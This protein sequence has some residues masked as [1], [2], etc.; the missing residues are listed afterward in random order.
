MLV[1]A[2]CAASL[3]VPSGVPSGAVM[4]TPSRSSGIRVNATLAAPAETTAAY[5]TAIPSRFTH[6]GPDSTRRRAPIAIE[7]ETP[8]ASAYACATCDVSMVAPLRL[9]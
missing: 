6:G 8:T 9:T 3:L 2:D 5:G 7:H 4:G 1:T